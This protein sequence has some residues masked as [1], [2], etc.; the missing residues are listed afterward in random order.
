VADL[1][2]AKAALDVKETTCVLR[3][4]CLSIS[5]SLVGANLEV[6]NF[7]VGDCGAT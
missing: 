3:P 7:F 4:F 5:L 1:S 2:A 6:A